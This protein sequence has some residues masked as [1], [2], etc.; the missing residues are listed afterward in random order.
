MGDRVSVASTSAVYLKFADENA[1]TL[2]AVECV[3]NEVN[4]ASRL[5]KHEEKI[6]DTA[7]FRHVCELGS[8]ELQ[9]ISFFIGRMFSQ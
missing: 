8:R 5:E 4:D 9:E 6:S 3:T 7:K 1:K 2:D